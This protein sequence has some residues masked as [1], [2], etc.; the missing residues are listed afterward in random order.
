MVYLAR[1]VDS[2]QGAEDA[3]APLPSAWH[4]AGFGLGV[5]GELLLFG[6]GEVSGLGEGDLHSNPFTPLSALF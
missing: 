6:L 3:A 2:E 4:A 5:E 1:E